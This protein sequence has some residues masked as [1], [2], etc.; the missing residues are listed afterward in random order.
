M[1]YQLEVGGYFLI[2][3]PGVDKEHLLG[4]PHVVLNTPLLDEAA[5]PG[6]FTQK[7][8]IDLLKKSIRIRRSIAYIEHTTNEFV[9]NMTEAIIAIPESLMV[10]VKYDSWLYLTYHK[11][12][13]F[14]QDM[15]QCTAS[16]SRS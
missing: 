15:L 1:E 6:L 7:K 13:L 4:R 11:A 10:T 3:P 8:Y 5:N 14:L 2:G 12:R 16:P 9:R